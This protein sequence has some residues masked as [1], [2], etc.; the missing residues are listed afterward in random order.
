MIK[1][2]FVKLFENSFRKNYDVSAFS[3]F[4]ET[5]TFTYG[6]VAQQISK[7]HILF[8]QCN[9]KKQDKIAL[10]GKNNSNWAITYLATVTYGAVIVPILQDFNSNDIH[11]ILNHSESK[12][13]FISDFLRER[14]E[15]EKL[16]TVEVAFSLTNFEPI[17]ILEKNNADLKS[18]KLS[19]KYINQL[20]SEK[21]KKG[22]S[23]KEIQYTE[24]SN[25]DLACLSYTSGTTGFSKGV[26]LSG[27]ALAGNITYGIRTN[28][29]K[30]GDKVVSFLP[31][32]HAYGCAFEF[33]TATSVGAH[34]HF[35]GRPPVAKFL[36]KAF[37]EVRPNVIFSVPLILEKIYKKQLQPTLEKPIVRL[38]SH[39]PLLN[40]VFYKKINERLVN[41]FGG[42]FSQ[43][44]I[45]GA[46]LN[47]E[48]ERFFCKMKFP[49]TVGY[50]MTE[51]APL[52]SYVHKNNFIPKSSGQVLDVMEAKI[53]NPNPKTGVGEL[54]VKGENLMLGYYKNQQA[55]D[56][57]IDKEGWFHTGDLGVLDE[58]NNVFIKGRSKTMILSASGQNIYPEEIEAKL[59]NMHY[60]MESL[61]LQKG[62]GLIAFVYPDYLSAKIDGIK[63][64]EL[65][66][67]MEE[68][69][70]E[71]NQLVAS[72]EAVREIRITSKEFEKTPK[73][74]IKRFLYADKV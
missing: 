25:A 70:K 22:F 16:D 72:Y 60:V 3:N 11:Y 12:L 39:L 43:I 30:Q 4:G 68:N 51:C 35:L 14:F 42:N 47:A 64:D 53:K 49:F 31:L 66:N 57:V 67:K 38:I 26:M 36:L 32:A 18:E 29:L 1:E 5:N 10:I 61:V 48:V 2:N 23:S 73:K 19:T 20:F 55:T 40:K 58:N 63:E 27:N 21:Y 71:L 28:L 6:E 9:I 37:S 45:G 52:I 8:E 54:Y 56:E 24:T 15:A 44:I 13:L 69:R 59:N 7:L 33:L 46:P 41:A 65:K 17:A 34:I 62:N 74:S 50:G